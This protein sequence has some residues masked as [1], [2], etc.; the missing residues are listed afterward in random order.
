MLSLVEPKLNNQRMVDDYFMDQQ[1]C[2]QKVMDVWL[3][4]SE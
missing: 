2:Q 3:R 4:L 1:E